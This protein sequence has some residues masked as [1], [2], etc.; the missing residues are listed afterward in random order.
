MEAENF[1]DDRKV[2]IEE[3]SLAAACHSGNLARNRT[4]RS[5]KDTRVSSSAQKANVGGPPVHDEDERV[6]L[7]LV[8]CNLV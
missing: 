2:V 5:W 6:L 3:E 8:C 7:G 1:E 4:R